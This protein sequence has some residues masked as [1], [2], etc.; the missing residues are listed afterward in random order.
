MLKRLAPILSVLTCVLLDT[1]VIPVLYRGVYVVPLSLLAVIAIA[2]HLGRMRGMLYGMIAGLLLD[3]T[4]GNMGLKLFPYILIG[5]VIG[6]LLDQHEMP[7]RGM[8]KAERIRVITVRAV[9]VFVLYAI[10]EITMLIYQY[11]STAVFKWVFVRNLSV[12]VCLFTVLSLL[13]HGLFYRIY[14]GKRTQTHKDAR[15]REVKHF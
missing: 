3:I 5:F 9:W 12:R 15:Y 4:T 7:H 14:I 10:Y 13:L 11:F 2:V 6:F 8:E 1:A